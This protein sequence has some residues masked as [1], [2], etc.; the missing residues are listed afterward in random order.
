MQKLSKV[1]VRLLE[2]LI[3]SVSGYEMGC[4]EHRQSLQSSLSTLR[5]HKFL[6]VSSIDVERNYQRL[7]EKLT[8]HSQDEKCEHLRLFLERFLESPIENAEGS[9]GVD[10]SKCGPSR[11]ELHYE[12]LA[13]LWGLQTSPQAGVYRP[14]VTSIPPPPP[15]EEQVDWHQLLVE[16]VSDLVRNDYDSD[17]SDYE[18]DEEMDDRMPSF[19]R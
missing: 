8:I 2:Q 14:K 11:S 19:N 3:S 18:E 4:E 10:P 16:D 6:S 9:T 1:Q 5:F 17:S 15:A 7:L 13:F 12:M